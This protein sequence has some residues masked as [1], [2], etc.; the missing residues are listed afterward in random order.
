ML[1]A[2][3]NSSRVISRETAN[4]VIEKQKQSTSYTYHA[5]RPQ[6]REMGSDLGPIYCD[7][8]CRITTGQYQRY[9]DVCVTRRMSVVCQ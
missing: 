4:F 1:L 6:Y 7:F 5:F 3:C 2:N 8:V 9:I